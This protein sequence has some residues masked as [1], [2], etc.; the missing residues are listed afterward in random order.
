MKRK[1]HEAFRDVTTFGLTSLDV[2]LPILRNLNVLDYSA[3]VYLGDLALLVGLECCPFEPVSNVLQ[4]G[5]GH[6]DTVA[7]QIGTQLERSKGA[8]IGCNCSRGPS[9]RGGKT[10]Q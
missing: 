7:L 9:P 10:C 2:S 3:V 1:F 5:T 8:H 6:S 4:L